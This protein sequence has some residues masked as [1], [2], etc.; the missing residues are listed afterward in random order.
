MWGFKMVPSSTRDQGAVPEGRPWVGLLGAAG[1]R[2]G[3]SKVGLLLPAALALSPSQKGFSP[4][5]F[6]FL[7]CL[8]SLK[9]GLPWW[10]TG[11]ESA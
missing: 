4:E 7:V 9:L 11:K 2:D 5:I 1:F 8:M 3:A 10:L 6:S